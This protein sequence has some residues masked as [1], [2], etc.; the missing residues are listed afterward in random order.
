M[1][2]RSAQ[3]GSLSQIQHGFL[4]RDGGVS[5]GVYES[6]NCGRANGDDKEHVAENRRRAVAAVDENA[7]LCT[8]R[9]IHGINAI[10]VE[11]AW[12]A[13]QAPQADALVTNRTG[14]ALGVSTADCAP[15]LIADGSAGIVAAAHAGWRGALAG[16]IEATIA[17]MAKIG[18]APDRMI[19]AVGPCIAKQSYEVGPEFPAPFLDQDPPNRRFFEQCLD[20]THYHFDL[21]AYVQSRLDLSGVPTTEVLGLDT[22][23]DE[24]RFF[25][26]RRACLRGEAAFG[27]S[28]SVISID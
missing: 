16:I 19:A 18:G 6:L 28:L 21:A 23:A 14:V 27:L 22:C 12:P 25:S 7:S 8:A 11:A 1:I 13:D 26:Y 17:A 3:L 5:S 2:V 15:I 9:Q 24:A 10:T 4:T 20:K